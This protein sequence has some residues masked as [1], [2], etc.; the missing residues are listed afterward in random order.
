LSREL[1]IFSKPFEPQSTGLLPR[2]AIHTKLDH[3]Q[4]RR[5]VWVHGPAGVGKTA[6]TV[7]YLRSRK[8]SYVWYQVD[9]M[10]IQIGVFLKNIASLADKSDGKYKVELPVYGGQTDDSLSLFS[11]QYF[12]KFFDLFKEPTAMVFDN[13]HE[14]SENSDLYAVLH[15]ACQIAPEHI[16]FYFLSRLAPHKQFTRCLLSS[17]LGVIHW[18]DLRF[19]PEE[20]RLLAATVDKD[21]VVAGELVDKIHYRTDGWAALVRI[22]LQQCAM[23]VANPE[24]CCKSIPKVILLYLEAELFDPLSEED[25]RFLLATAI[26]PFISTET[27]Q[28]AGDFSDLSEMMSRLCKKQILISHSSSHYQYHQLFREFLIQKAQEATEPKAAKDIRRKAIGSFLSQ[29]R[30][31]EALEVISRTE[32]QESSIRTMV[33]QVIDRLFD[34]NFQ[35]RTKSLV[36]LAENDADKDPWLMLIHGISRMKVDSSQ[37]K[38]ML[39]RSYDAFAQ[40]KSDTGKLICLTSL[41]ETTLTQ[42]WDDPGSIDSLLKKIPEV[43]IQKVDPQITMTT[44]ARLLKSVLIAMTLRC[45]NPN[46]L[47]KWEQRALTGIRNNAKPKTRSQLAFGLAWKNLLLGESAVAKGFFDIACDSA[48]NENEAPVGAVAYKVWE[49]FYLWCEGR[50]DQGYAVG[51]EGLKLLD[52]KE[53]MS[54]LYYLN[55]IRIACDLGL[56]QLKRARRMLK[57]LLKDVNSEDHLKMAV[58]NILQAWAAMEEDKSETAL[59]HTL[60]AYRHAMDSGFPIFIAFTQSAMALAYGL[61][62]D[63]DQ[64]RRNLVYANAKSR[65]IGAKQI[66]YLCYMIDAEIQLDDTNQEKALEPLE[67]AFSLGRQKEYANVWLWRPDAVIKLCSKALEAGIETQYVQDLIRQRR[68]KPPDSFGDSGQWPWPIRIQTL[69][70]F[71]VTVDEEEIGLFGR[72]KVPI[73]LLKALIV[74]GIGGKAILVNDILPEL[75]PDCDNVK[76][77][78]TFKTNLHRLRKILGYEEAVLVQKKKISLN[79]VICWVDIW[80]FDALLKE[81]EKSWKSAMVSGGS[82]QHA[83]HLT[84]KVL[85]RLTSI[86]LPEL[87]DAWVIY[88]RNELKKRYLF[89]LKQ[90]CA[91]YENLS[92]WT[93]AIEAYNKGLSVY[94]DEE[95]LYQC[96][97]N[98]YNS[99]GLRSEA[100]GVFR[101]CNVMMTSNLGKPPSDKTKGIFKRSL[102]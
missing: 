56:Q 17:K 60:S 86:L 22:W 8:T 27:A 18:E 73:L 2:E 32:N 67:K 24:S 30:Y 1:C 45:P 5:G 6:T 94:S 63:M 54:V 10:D 50:F 49:A 55:C 102:S 13:L 72:I 26:F 92:E 52:Q 53:G 19:S 71:S 83:I 42:S 87:N 88:Y 97:M 57:K 77:M 40:G 89:I 78:N 76:A 15:I 43:D 39:E 65:K 16:G 95:D 84:Q 29:G 34:G 11:R 70:Q 66:Q 3:F 20:T 93:M 46:E 62:G 74:K 61:T 101:F 75:W 4:G 37:C 91:H 100:I 25:Q 36:S 21:A 81:A 58:L 68:L 14:V 64:A 38:Q 44:E 82:K 41:F 51:G 69:N 7:G 12:S 33:V 85:M 9:V 80:E 90:L 48:K 47:K 59:D 31:G 98:C 23:G 96:L 28:S 79:P 35:T 99:A